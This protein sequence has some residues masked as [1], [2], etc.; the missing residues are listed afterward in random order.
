MRTI[1]HMHV[2]TYHHVSCCHSVSLQQQLVCQRGLAMVYVGDNAEIPDI[3]NWD[4]CQGV[5][6]YKRDGKTTSS[7][8]SAS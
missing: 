4:L 8:L 7:N 2:S 1:E 3:G 6:A 5:C